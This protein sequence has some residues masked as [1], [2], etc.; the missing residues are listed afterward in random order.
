MQNC[1]TFRHSLATRLLQNGNAIRIVQG[2]LDH[3]GVKTTMVY[4]HVL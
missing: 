1:H 3:E 2:L 4:A